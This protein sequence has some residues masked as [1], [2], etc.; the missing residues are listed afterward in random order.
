MRQEPA[1]YL[2][3]FVEVNSLRFCI[4]GSVSKIVLRAMASSLGMSQDWR[5]GVLL[6]MIARDRS[7]GG[8]VGLGGLSWV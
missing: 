2:I 6:R 8:F 5:A 3:L 4:A 7:V 1:L